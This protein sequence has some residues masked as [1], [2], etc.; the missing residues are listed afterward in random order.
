[1]LDVLDAVLTLL[2]PGGAVDGTT[3]LRPATSGVSVDHNGARPWQVELAPGTLYGW[4]G[5]DRHRVFE[6]GDPPSER[7]EFQLELLYVAESGEQAKSRMQ[8]AISSAIDTKAHEYAAVVAANKAPKSDAG[9]PWSEL[10]LEINP[11]TV[12]GFNVRGVGLRL[13]GWRQLH[14]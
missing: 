2:E 3:G 9:L 14:D 11:D 10:N 12:R 8:R 5:A 1:M 13:T 6:L 7:E 4:P